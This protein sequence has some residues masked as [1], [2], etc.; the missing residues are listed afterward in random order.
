MTLTLVAC[1]ILTV[2][3]LNPAWPWPTALAFLGARP[4]EAAPN[5]LILYAGATLAALLIILTLL[6]RRQAPSFD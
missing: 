5:L 1:T 3:A 4:P 6:A 2:P